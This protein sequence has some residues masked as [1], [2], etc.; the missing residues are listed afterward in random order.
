MP[1]TLARR[2]DTLLTHCRTL[3][4]KPALIGTQYSLTYAGLGRRTQAIV[5]ALL[6]AP[7]GMVLIHG[8]K[9]L[10][11]VPAMMAATFAKR[12]FVFA[13]I[14]YPM[15]R[16][17]QIIDT[18]NCAVVLRTD[19]N[20]P[21]TDLTTI[22]TDNLCDRIL[23]SDLRLEP[24][25]EEQ[26]FY[27]TFTSGS[28]GVPKGIPTTRASYAALAEWFEPQNSGSAGGAEGHISHASMAFDMSMSDIWTALFAGRSIY[29]LDHTNTLSPRA[30]IRHLM[31]EA[32]AVPGTLTST[33]AFY[34]LML[35]DPKFNAKTFPE[36]KSFW[37]G[38]EAVQR[39][40]LM[41]L[42]ERFPKCEIYHAYGPS[43]CA[44]ITHSHLL[45]DAELAGDGP[46]PLGPEQ[47][48][49]AVL[50][51]TGSGYETTGEGEVVLVGPQ[52]G[53]CYW[54]INHPN[55]AN[56]GTIQ[57]QRSY[58]TGDHGEIDA[59]G[60]LKIH[61]RIDNQV[62]VNGFRIE[63]GEIER[64]AAEV[65]G[66]RQ[67]IAMQ[68]AEG[69]PT[70]GLI[71]VVNGEGLDT[72]TPKTKIDHVRDHL[73]ASLPPF[74]VPAKI[75]VAPQLPMSHAGKIDRRAMQAQFAAA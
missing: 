61:G 13:D 62:K 43:E 51:D 27:V 28:T 49:A 40:L 68:A 55:N 48:G 64:S 3:G 54:P 73:R 4:A 53:S 5:H 74:M 16:I 52:V 32:D 71:L 39:A 57:G 72:Q 14:S 66:V 17:Q 50:V 44:C 2:F 58:H 25:D 63:L 23:E 18:C 24:K 26:L 34:E 8:H 9:E 46:L 41:R 31:R 75:L 69:G 59:T 60:S 38:G 29:L 1:H 15:S 42:R 30:N 21:T 19:S 47:I 7:K 45:S 35:E 12:G 37:I 70:R 22:T 33:P 10:D 65:D 11:I 20:A 56:F 6:S 36:L 67:A